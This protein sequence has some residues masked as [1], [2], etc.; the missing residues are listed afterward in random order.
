M[1]DLWDREKRLGDMERYRADLDEIRREKD[2]LRNSR[3]EA[4]SIK[5]PDSHHN[6]L[7]NPLPYNIQNP[8]LLRQMQSQTNYK[9]G[10]RY[11]NN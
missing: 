11:G 5:Y 1:R 10:Q 8:Y 3:T 9:Q 4:Q 6:I 7:V 2:V